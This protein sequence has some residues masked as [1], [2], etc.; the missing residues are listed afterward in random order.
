MAQWQDYLDNGGDT[1]GVPKKLPC[2]AEGTRS[3]APAA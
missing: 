2:F 1:I 3:S